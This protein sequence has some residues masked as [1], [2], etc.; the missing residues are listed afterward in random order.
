MKN[1]RPSRRILGLLPVTRWSLGNWVVI[2][3][4][5]FLCLAGGLRAAGTALFFDGVNDYVTFGPAP[6]LGTATFTIE[7]WFKRTGTGVGTS[8]G[9]GGVTAVP[10]VTKGRAEVDGTN[11]DMNYFLGI[12]PTDSVL[13]ADFEEGAGAASP[14][15]NHPIAGITPIANNVWYH[16]AVTYDGAKLQL[17]LNGVL[18]SQLTVGQPP[19]S[20]SIQHAALGSALDSTGTASGFFAG[21]LDE[22]RIWNYARSAQDISANKANEI[23]SAIGLLG[24]W[25]L[26]E[27]TGTIASSSTGIPLTGTLTNG[28]V[29]VTGIQQASGPA[30]TRGPYLQS[31]TPTGMIIRW[32]TETATASRVSYGT[33]AGQLNSLVDDATV[34]TEHLVQITGLQPNS[35]YFYGVGSPSVTLASGP[36]FNFFTAPAV[37]TVLPLRFWILGDS[38]EANPNAASV[39]NAYLNFN[40]NRYTDLLLMLGDNAYENGTDAEYQSAVFN[41]Y[42]SMLRQTPLWPTIGNHDTA[43]STNPALTIP[44]F[45][46]FTLP[47]NA[48]A[49]GVVSGTEKYYSFDYGNVHFICLDSMTSSRSASGPMATWLQADLSST[50]QDWIIAFFHHPPYCKGVIDSDTAV[51]S[52]EMRSNFLPILEAGGVDLVLSGHSHDYERSFSLNGHYG[53]SSTLTS[54]MKVNSGSGRETDTGAYQKPGSNAANSGAVYV[55]AG[56]SGEVLPGPLNHPAMYIS[57][58]SLGSLVL[59]LDG[60]RL[61]AKFLREN[62]TV[63]DFFTI[64]KPTNNHPPNV[65]MSSPANGATFTGPTDVALSVTASDTDGQVVRVDYYATSTLIGTST[66]A[67]FGITW[68][69]VAAGTYS[70]TAIA[71]DDRGAATTSA[72]VS[73]TVGTSSP[74]AAPTGLVAAPGDK[75]VTLNWNAAARATSYSVKGATVIGGPYTTIASGLTATTYTNIGLTNGTK[76]FY[77]VTASNL[78][79]QS[80][81]SNEASATPLSPPPTAPTN[82]NARAASKS[83]VNLSWTDNS[84]NETGFQI[85]RSPNG[86]TFA[87][88]ATVG[89][90]VTSYANTSLTASTTYYY[91]VRAYNLGGNSPYSN[92]A[93]AKT[94]K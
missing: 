65:A 83:R 35:Q 80:G 51:E 48:E 34:T 32:R 94:P 79:G 54:A 85:E 11:V 26:N 92:T 10:L 39:R 55:V 64:Q 16:A 74:P 73:I 36:D 41:T 2:A 90:G 76:Y 21:A 45:Q 50:T 78:G 33:A 53:L 24:R 40:G 1:H 9:S 49:G 60:G 87:Q 27:G 18:E 61:D 67:P 3:L 6:S 57:L 81:V 52:I 12:R 37:G 91:R 77:V 20:D 42:P 7:T 17:F 66:T 13:V 84:N 28:P 68:T 25:G 70:L 71:T 38:G 59:D 47:T 56:S 69:N 75:Q 72:A 29:W 5:I 93:S 88:I 15:L 63:A 23:Y 19:R 62:G 30:V 4:S 22:V 89:A 58:L 8:T 14:G 31:G 43:Q 82:L 44:Y 46:I 86:T